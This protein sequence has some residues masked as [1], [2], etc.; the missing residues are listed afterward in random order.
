[1]RLQEAFIFNSKVI[2][3]MVAFAPWHLPY[4]KQQKM[5][6]LGLAMTLLRSDGRRG[7]S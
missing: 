6:L 1:M 7:H 2:S 3:M 5:R 4:L